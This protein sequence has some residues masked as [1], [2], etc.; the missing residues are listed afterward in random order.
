M[1]CGEKQNLSVL[2]DPER[3]E[4]LTFIVS[5]FTDVLVF[6][7]YNVVSKTFIVTSF[8]GVLVV[9]TFTL[10]LKTLILAQLSNIQQGTF[11]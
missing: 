6:F 10:V 3:V 1:K 11:D 8:T 2:N 5:S 4:Y 9:F 7:T